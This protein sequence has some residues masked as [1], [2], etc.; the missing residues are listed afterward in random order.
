MK[1]DIKKLLALLLFGAAALSGCAID[2]GRYHRDSHYDRYHYRNGAYTR[3][4][5][6]YHDRDNG[7][8]YHDNNY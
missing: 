5:D 8:H 2:S 4:N 1:K 3:Y 6:G 7:Y